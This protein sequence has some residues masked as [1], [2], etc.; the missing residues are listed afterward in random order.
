[1]RLFALSIFISSL[2]GCGRSEPIP[3]RSNSKNLFLAL[4][5]SYTIGESVDPQDRW[6]VQLARM[7]REK[8]ADVADPQ[9]IATTGWTTDEL[10]AGM[11]AAT[12][13]GPYRLVTLLI[14]VNNQYRGRDVGEFRTQFRA[15]LSRAVALAGNKPS[16]VIV[17]SIPDYGV[18]P[19]AA[20]SDREK[21][22]RSIAAFNSVCREESTTAG[23]TFVDITPISRDA[24]NDGSLVADDGLHPSGKMYHQWSQKILPEAQRALD[25]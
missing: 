7:L 8:G 16:R 24:A 18:T 5:D 4:G 22:A 6:P 1:M 11:D 21:I 23:A 19:F 2:L 12:P 20:S 25:H 10:S 9:I 14:G 13:R 3:A 17:V 15:L